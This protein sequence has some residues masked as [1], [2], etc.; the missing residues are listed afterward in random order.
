MSVSVSVRVCVCGQ[1][2]KLFN[3]FGSGWDIFLKPFGDIP[4]MFVHQLQI[5]LY[6][7]YVCQ[8]ISWLTS[9]LK[10]GYYRDISSSW[11]DI[12]LKSFGDIPGMFVH[13]GRIF[14]NIPLPLG[15]KFSNQFSFGRESKICWKLHASFADIIHTFIHIVTKIFI[16]NY[17]P[18]LFLCMFKILASLHSIWTPSLLV[19]RMVNFTHQIWGRNQRKLCVRLGK[20]FKV[21]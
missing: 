6:F 8:S 17:L 5:I 11:W 18:L 2:T 9:L 10:L 4:G 14:L 3:I 15:A 20:N 21:D 16:P 19:F 12:F 7:L 13:Q 1:L